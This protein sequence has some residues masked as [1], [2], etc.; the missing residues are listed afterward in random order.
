MSLTPR[1]AAAA[2]TSPK[3]P[4]FDGEGFVDRGIRAYRVP[5]W[6]RISVALVVSMVAVEGC[7][8]K[9]GTV[10]EESSGRHDAHG[11]RDD[12]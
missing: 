9:E 12:G 3:R 5:M 4:G 1:K 11:L 6:S 10:S 2:R 7:S 8:P